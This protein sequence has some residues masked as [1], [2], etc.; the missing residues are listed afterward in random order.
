MSATSRT[1]IL[2]L[3]ISTQY[4]INI[5]SGQAQTS[6]TGKQNIAELLEI[7][8]QTFNLVSQD[9]VILFDGC[10]VE[11]QAGGGLK[12]SVHRIIWINSAAV[13]RHYGDHR[14]PFDGAH[15]TFTVEALR[16]WRD[17]QWWDSDTTGIVETLPFAVQK[18]YDYTNMREMMLLHDGIELPC[19]LE[20]AYVIEDKEA[21]T[22]DSPHAEQVGRRGEEGLWLFAKD[23]PVALS[24]FTLGLPSDRTPRIYASEGV[25]APVFES[26]QQLG[27][28]IYTY[29]MENIPALPYPHTA[30]PAAYTPHVTWSTWD[31]WSELGKDLKHSLETALELDEALKDSLISLLD[32]AYTT[33]DKAKRIAEF[34]DRSTRYISYPERYWRWNHRPAHR[35]FAT[36]YGHRLDRAVLAA[37]LFREAGFKAFPVFRGTGFGDVNEDIASLIRMDGIA[38]WVSGEDMF[39]AYYDPVNSAI[40]NGLAPIYGRTVWIVGSGDEPRVTWDGEKMESR[41]EVRLRISYDREKKIWH[42]RGYY[43][44]TQGLNPHHRMEG[45]ASEAQEFLESVL[46][47]V[48]NGAEIT[49][50]NPVTW[51]RFIISVGFEFTA[52]VGEVDPYGRHS[53]SIDEPAGG[54]FDRLP[55]DIELCVE[56]RNSPV[57]LPGLMEQIVEVSL[58]SEGWD[59]VYQPS[60]RALENDAGG[61]HI[62]VEEKDGRRVVTRQLRLTKAS[63]PAADWPQLRALLLADRSERNRTVLLKRID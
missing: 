50:Y 8:D 30:D 41:L 34:V 63:C 58:D 14:I 10:R 47:G 27:L 16:T 61:F 4:S 42:G 32:D 19:V 18:A 3:L 51:S 20:V 37:A 52:P 25:P 1:L 23:D 56:E 29:E 54:V 13:V 45:V 48:I 38:V 21:P 46:S 57:R 6:I 12:T 44:A 39:E 36:A 17:G 59:I 49:N 53:L 5:S 43:N 40:S 22:F 28:D 60:P 7:A 9:A 55:E 26:N 11:W 31:S 62:K 15:Q 33:T 2:A 35:T 24:Q